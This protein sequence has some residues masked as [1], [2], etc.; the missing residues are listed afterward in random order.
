MEARNLGGSTTSRIF[1]AYTLVY[2]EDLQPVFVALN[3]VMKEEDASALFEK[4][5]AALRELDGFTLEMRPEIF[6]Y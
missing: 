5:I 3:R 1:K 6:L 4:M 2:Q